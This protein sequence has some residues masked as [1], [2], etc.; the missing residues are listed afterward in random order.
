MRSLL[1]F[2]LTSITLA[3]CAPQDNAPDVRAAVEAAS[4]SLSDAVVVARGES[5][6]AVG[7]RLVVRAEPTFAV[8][9]LDANIAETLADIRIDS[10]DGRI[11]SRQQTTDTANVCADAVTL[12][13][14]IGAAEDEVGGEA[15][16]IELD[17]DGGCVRE[18]IVLTDA[19]LMEAE[20]DETGTVVEVEPADDGELEGD[21]ADDADEL[22]DD[23]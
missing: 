9:A 13:D 17:D 11:L 5:G 10:S 8:D 3:A 20:V 7:A 16:S 21:D 15:V 1:V 19:G 18:V 22:G 14:A 2:A 4:L 12:D 6:V 23:D